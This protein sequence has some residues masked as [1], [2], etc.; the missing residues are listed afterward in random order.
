MISDICHQG[1][2]DAFSVRELSGG[3]ESMRLSKRGTHHLKNHIGIIFVLIP[4]Y[5]QPVVLQTLLQTTFLQDFLLIAEHKKMIFYLSIHTSI[6][7]YIHLFIHP[8]VHS[9]IYLFIHSSHS[10]IHAY[11]YSFLY[12]FLHS[13][14]NS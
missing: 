10:C 13:S 3:R 11:M 4:V 7:F 8:S 12:S 5:T 1:E 6:Y 9:F 14:I 2:R